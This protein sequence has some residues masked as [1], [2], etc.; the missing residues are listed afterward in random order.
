MAINSPWQLRLKATGT[1]GNTLAQL[2]G[3]TPTA[4]SRQWLRST[5]DAYVTSAVRA[6]EIMTPEQRAEWLGRS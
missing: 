6:L 3:I 5:P 1:T 4:L 2:L